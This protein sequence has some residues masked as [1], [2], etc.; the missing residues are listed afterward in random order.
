MQAHQE[1][2][3]PDLPQRR[4]G[5]SVHHRRTHYSAQAVLDS[6]FEVLSVNFEMLCV[7]WQTLAWSN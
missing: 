5:S 6:N 4:S 2:R 3:I 7:F 1:I